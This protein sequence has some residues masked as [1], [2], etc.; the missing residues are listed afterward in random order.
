MPL[1]TRRFPGVSDPH[2]DY[3]RVV[4]GR[5]RVSVVRE[6]R[7]ARGAFVTPPAIAELV[8]GWA[9]CDR[10]DARAL[11]PTCGEAVFLL[12]AGRRLQAAG[13]A[14]EDLDQHLYGIDLHPESLRKAAHLLESEG[15]DAHLMAA[16]FFDV[17]TPEQL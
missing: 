14:L 3:I 9:V 16:D 12:A 7:K 4:S 5:G 2:L 13:C 8:A 17:D 11:D 15:L 10:P 1:L 6:S